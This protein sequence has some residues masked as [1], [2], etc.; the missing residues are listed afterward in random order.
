MSEFTT[1]SSLVIAKYFERGSVI[2][3]TLTK[4]KT[5]VT[6]LLSIDFDSMDD[7]EHKQALTIWTA[8]LED[9]IPRLGS[10]EHI[11]PFMTPEETK[12]LRDLVKEINLLESEVYILYITLT[13]RVSGY[14][15]QEQR[16]A[17]AKK[18]KSCLCN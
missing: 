11:L 8:F 5:D 6:R 4:F 15:T 1:T 7:E 10:N 18:P 13:P 16:D 12:Q 2:I 9:P 14:V 3:K 17:A